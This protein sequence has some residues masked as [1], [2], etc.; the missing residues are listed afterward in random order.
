MKKALLG[1]SVAA[2][3]L[4]SGSTLAAAPFA[5][6]GGSISVKGMV[7]SG[8]CNISVNG[9]TSIAL[10]T[11][12]KADFVNNDEVIHQQG[13]TIGFTGC[14]ETIAKATLKFINDGSEIDSTT[15][16]L[17]NSNGSAGAKSVQVALEDK[18]GA[19]LKLN[20]SGTNVET[21]IASG[22]GTMQLSAGYVTNNKD[23]VTNGAVD[24]LVRF[25]VDY[26]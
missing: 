19:V 4:V 22:S 2:T 16:Y 1:M 15:G 11:A 5:Q 7:T 17:I 14:D 25:S 6:D 9:G 26:I 13:F 24:A 21:E 8:T 23:A 12:L 20:E 18:T 3:L 10:E